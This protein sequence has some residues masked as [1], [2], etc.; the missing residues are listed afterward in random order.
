MHDCRQLFTLIK[1]VS[2]YNYTLF[3]LNSVGVAGA[4]ILSGNVLEPRALNELLPNWEQDGAPV[5]VKATQDR[6]ACCR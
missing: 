5:T 6:C 2:R 1:D 3:V 4:H